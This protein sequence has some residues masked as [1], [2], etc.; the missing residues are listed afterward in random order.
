[1]YHVVMTKNVMLD[2]V[3]TKLFLAWISYFG[4]KCVTFTPNGINQ[5]IFSDQISAEA[6]CTEI[7]F[8]NFWI[9]LMSGE[10]GPNCSQT[11]C[12]CDKSVPW[13]NIRAIK[14]GIRIGSD[15][16]QMGQIW[17]FLRSLSVHF[18]SPSQNVWNWPLKKS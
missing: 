8:E 7:W 9:C 11:W 5:G 1:M 15:W 13:R 3:I 17:E 16:P 14:F 6:K 12:P 4:P 2:L 18:G 10:F